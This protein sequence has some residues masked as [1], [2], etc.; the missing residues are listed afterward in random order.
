MYNMN[1]LSVLVQK[2][3]P[4]LSFSKVG[5]KSRS[6]SQGGNF[7]HKQKGLATR[8]THLFNESPISFGS[9][10]IAKVKFFQKLVK[11]QGQGHK[12]KHFGTD[13]KVFSNG[14]HACNMKALSLIIKKL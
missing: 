5:Q 13:R 14:I 1:A 11:I 10:V 7:W 12:V 9:K 2:L 3:W 4:R 6:S 8:N